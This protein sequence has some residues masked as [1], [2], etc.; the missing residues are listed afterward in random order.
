MI[1]KFFK[2]VFTTLRNCALL[3]AMS[4]VW[5]GLVAALKVA[6]AV[7]EDVTDTAVK[8]VTPFILI[9][10]LLRFLVSPDG[11]EDPPC[12][13][14]ERL[15]DK[16]REIITTR[17]GPAL[18]FFASMSGLALILS[19]AVYQWAGIP[20]DGTYLILFGIVLVV[21]GFLA[22]SWNVSEKRRMATA[23]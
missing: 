7:Q 21:L 15:F 22:F 4:F 1:R 9:Y 10:F 6:F 13:G 11:E 2:Q 12:T 23:G 8:A 20:F 16:C 14:L 19:I 17:N 18:S 5:V 3:F